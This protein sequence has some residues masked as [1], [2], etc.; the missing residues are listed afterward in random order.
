MNLKFKIELYEKGSRATLY[1]VRLEGESITE[2]EKFL[3]NP[4]IKTNPEFEPLVY[5]L[6]D[7][8]NKYGC[9]E[10]FFK[11]KESRFNDSVVALWR[12][13]IRL[14]CCRY[15]NIILIL[16]S[17]GIKK[18]KTYQEDK[19]LNNIVKIMSEISNRID[20]RIIEEKTLCIE[21]NIFVGNLKFE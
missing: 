8:L 17:G 3:S 9:Q 4:E 11:L 21:D 15:S 16:G 10:R 1:T 13:N 20:K 6:D 18:T 19:Y 5:G 12:G 2:F 14:Y 7:I